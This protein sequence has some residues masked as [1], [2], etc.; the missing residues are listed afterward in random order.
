MP[1]SLDHTMFPHIVER[2]GRYAPSE[3]RFTSRH[4]ATRVDSSAA[5]WR[6][7]DAKHPTAPPTAQLARCAPHDGEISRARYLDIAGPPDPRWTFPALEVVRYLHSSHGNVRFEA[8]TVILYGPTDWTMGSWSQ[9]ASPDT[10]DRLDFKA[11][12]S[13]PET[14]EHVVM[15]TGQTIYTETP[16]T[17]A[18]RDRDHD[19]STNDIVFLRMINLLR[20]Q[21]HVKRLTVV[22]R[23][24]ANPTSL[25]FF[26]CI[27][28]RITFNDL[29]IT[30][31]CACPEDSEEH[32][33][34]HTAALRAV[35]ADWAQEW[36]DRLEWCA[37]YDADPQMGY[38]WHGGFA[39]AFDILERFPPD[40]FRPT[41]ERVRGI[42]HDEWHDEVG[43][44]V[45]R[46]ATE[47]IEERTS[48]QFLEDE[49]DEQDE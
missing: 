27:P 22:L 34:H 19:R 41:A 1:A 20:N 28:H 9:L 30:L 33:Q 3:L 42:S 44:T 43:E 16:G 26:Y 13:F 32:T 38:F 8:P 6:I 35:A 18:S 15:S 36:L 25:A 37:Y 49:E 7:Q 29:D 12:L 24:G 10:S 39:E 17:W 46:L 5:H 45:F 2:I 4:W 48:E 40:T 21:P 31:V 14:V 23:D 47:H 11:A